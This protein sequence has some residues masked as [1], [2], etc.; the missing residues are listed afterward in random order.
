MDVQGLPEGLDA[1]AADACADGVEGEGGAHHRQTGR[2]VR[3]TLIGSG[4]VEMM[5]MVT[6][7]S[8]YSNHCPAARNTGLG[9]GQIGWWTLD[10]WSDDQCRSSPSCSC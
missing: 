2:L 6:S 5:V 10:R 9:D 1:V 7:R 8:R 3:P 4:V